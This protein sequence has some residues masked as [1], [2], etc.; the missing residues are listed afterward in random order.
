MFSDQ[1]H[2]SGENHGKAKGLSA[3]FLVASVTEFRRAFEVDVYR[4]LV[5]VDPVSD[6]WLSS[7]QKV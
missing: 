1:T 6:H 3:L 5:D 2:Q 4:F 7:L